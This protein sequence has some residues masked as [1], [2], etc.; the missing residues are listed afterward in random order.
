LNNFWDNSFYIN[1]NKDIEDRFIRLVIS[2]KWVVFWLKIKKTEYNFVKEKLDLL[3]PKLIENIDS[4]ESGTWTQVEN[5]KI[6]ETRKLIEK[7]DLI[8]NQKW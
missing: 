5:K 3:K 6:I 8:E 2:N 7:K 4:V 1:L